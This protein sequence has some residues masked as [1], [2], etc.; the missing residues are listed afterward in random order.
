MPLNKVLV[1]AQ[2][3]LRLTI[4]GKIQ[5]KPIKTKVSF[6]LSD[7]TPEDVYFEHS[8]GA[9]QE[10]LERLA[11]EKYP[12]QKVGIYGSNEYHIESIDSFEAEK[13]EE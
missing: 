4:D 11:Q 12:S 6:E 8:Q 7:T 5:K 2:L 1:T 10:T 13:A 3:T 9:F